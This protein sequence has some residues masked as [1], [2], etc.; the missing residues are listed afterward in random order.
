MSKTYKTL[1][2]SLNNPEFFSATMDMARQ[3]SKAYDSHIIGLYVVPSVIVYTA[4]GGLSHGSNFAELSEFYA[5]QAEH[6][7]KDFKTYIK[8][9]GLNAEWRK[10]SSEGHVISRNII[11]HGREA[12]LIVLGDDSALATET[13]FQGRIVKAS[14]RPVMI[15]PQ[16]FKPRQKS[17]DM[18]FDKTL[19]AWDGSREASRAAFDALPLL[20]LSQATKITCI[21][22]HKERLIKSDLPGAE[23]AAALSRY[24]VTVDVETITTRKSVGKALINA[25][26]AADLLVMGG[27]GHARLF[28]EIFGGATKAILKATPCPIL[29]SN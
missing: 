29:L 22:P 14:G 2:V 25:A 21:N 5:K 8:T 17:S 20:G 28:E 16:S 12:D 6:V 15:V 26:Q 10:V 7:A 4:S 23:L 24:D 1:L 3:I 18:L 27:Y 11:E 9:H 19:I 13:H